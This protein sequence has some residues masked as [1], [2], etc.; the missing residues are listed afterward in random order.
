MR[1]LI[2]ALLAAG[3][4]AT[5]AI[6]GLPEAPAVAAPA[7]AELAVGAVA[8]FTPSAEPAPAPAVRFSDDEG[9][10]VTLER[11]RGKVVL[12]NFWATWCAP[13]RREMKD[14]DALQAKLGGKDFVVVAV[15]GDRQG[16]PVVRDFFKSLK[17]RHLSLYNE[18]QM[19]PH[20]AFHAFGLPTT[21]LLDRQGR[22]LGR[23]VGPADWS[24]KEA[25][26][27]IRHYIGQPAG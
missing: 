1:K 19:A 5:G 14:L 11:F 3:C 17:I 25:M 22:E 21:V 2:C 12:L 26:A 9:K 27:L 16:L 23:M 13:C 4:V 7:A 20:R 6:A 15:S 24:S 10:T 18:P 8:N